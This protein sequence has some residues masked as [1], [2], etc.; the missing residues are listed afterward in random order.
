MTDRGKTETIKRLKKPKEE[1]LISTQ[2]THHFLWRK[3]L[4][5]S[6]PHQE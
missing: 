1:A 3:R 4:S 6:R 5:V 2:P